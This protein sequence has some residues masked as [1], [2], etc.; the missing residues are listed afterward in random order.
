MSSELTTAQA[1]AVLGVHPVTLR[2]WRKRSEFIIEFD[3]YEDQAGLQWWYKNDRRIMYDAHYVER[4]KRI[5]SRRK[6]TK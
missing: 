6:G 5:L 2:K 1:A 3:V 4:L